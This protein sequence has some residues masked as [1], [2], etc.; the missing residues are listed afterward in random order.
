MA[1]VCGCVLL[2]LATG[3]TDRPIP[4]RNVRTPIDHQAM[5]SLIYKYAA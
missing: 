1:N 3:S 2:F 4:G 5:S